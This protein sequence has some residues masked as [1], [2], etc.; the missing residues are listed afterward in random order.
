MTA[1]LK[2]PNRNMDHLAQRILRLD[3]QVVVV[4]QAYELFLAQYKLRRREIESTPEVDL[5]WEEISYLIDPRDVH[6]FSMFLEVIRQNREEAVRCLQTSSEIFE[7]YKSRLVPSS[8]EA[9]DP[10]EVHPPPSKLRAGKSP[11]LQ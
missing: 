1:N 8:V 10:G 11:L 6:G 9:S 7:F 2:D 3:G 4:N 5:L